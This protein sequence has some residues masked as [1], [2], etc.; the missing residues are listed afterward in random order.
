MQCLVN[1]WHPKFPP[2]AF[3]AEDVHNAYPHYTMRLERQQGQY[4][5]PGR[6]P[7]NRPLVLPAVTVQ[8]ACKASATDGARMLARSMHL[9]ELHALLSR[10]H[11][12]DLTRIVDAL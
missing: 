1:K 8:V 11:L 9:I 6:A 3:M 7:R 10:L 4:R 12:S 5:A 2:A